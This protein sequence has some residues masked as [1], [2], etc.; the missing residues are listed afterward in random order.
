[1]LVTLLRASSPEF[2]PNWGQAIKPYLFLAHAGATRAYVKDDA[3]VFR[4]SSGAE[5]RLQWSGVSPGAPELWSTA[6][7]T[8][9]ISYY[10]NQPD[11][12]LCRKPVPTYRRLVRKELFP[13]IDW[14]LYGRGDAFEYDLIVH[15]GAR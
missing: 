8:G 15:P 7:P 4:G 1:M 13:R 12:E 14:A 5:V 11:A 6:E 2:E 3:L 9:N 10:C